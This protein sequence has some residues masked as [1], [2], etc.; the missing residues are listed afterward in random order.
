MKKN[1][2]NLVILANALT[3]IL[4]SLTINLKAQSFF[5][6]VRS[7]QKQANYCRS[8]MQ[9]TDGG[10]VLAGGSTTSP[11][12]E[13]ADSGRAFVVKV[14]ATGTPQWSKRFTSGPKV[15]NQVVP[16]SDGNFLTVGTDADLSG[17][18]T[19]QLTKAY[20]TKYDNTGNILWQ[21]YVGL[22]AEA[23]TCGILAKDGSN[24]LA[25]ASLKFSFTNPT[26]ELYVVKMNSDGTVA[27]T[28]SYGVSNI[29]LVVASSIKEVSSG[30]FIITGLTSSNDNDACLLR[31][32][33]N[34]NLLWSKLMGST[35][36]DIAADVIETADKGFLMLGSTAGAGGGASD[37]LLCKFASDGTLVWHKT[38]GEGLTDLA[39]SI[40][41]YGNGNYLIMGL[42]GSFGS[43][44]F[45][46]H[47]LVVDGNG[48][49]LRSKRFI[50]DA[51]PELAY[52]RPQLTKNAAGKY[53]LGGNFMNRKQDDSFDFGILQFDDGFST[54]ISSDTAAVTQG[55]SLEF[56]PFAP[57]TASRGSAS[58][59]TA[60]IVSGH[61]SSIVCPRPPVFN[62][63]VGN[64]SDPTTWSTGEV[65]L[66]TDEVT[67]NFDVTV[68]VDAICKS[69][70]VNN[71]NVH[72]NS[73]IQL[74]ILGQQ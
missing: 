38:I 36:D 6:L 46:N 26:I 23:F 15:W 43:R 74:Y 42:T 29:G 21:K 67:L 28:K 56:Y 72:V 34:G 22:L 50:T 45:D 68:D 53:V 5:K 57:T 59:F 16:T 48:N 65:P 41:D 8:I 64:W 54:C 44:Y 18:L 13:P 33:A 70:Q 19:A 24:I 47:L 61:S 31:I 7:Q 51:G 40:T 49:V 2:I 32:D 30:G 63:K 27:W 9:T 71:H 10:Y 37:Y 35:V 66:A 4:L 20:V 69:L 25:G 39:Y 62:V 60:T 17:D 52:T 12:D 11:V 3:V 14:D 55:S 73:N 1:R 58:N